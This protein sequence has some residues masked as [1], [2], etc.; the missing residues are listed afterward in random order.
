MVRAYREVHEKSA[1]KGINL[2]QAAFQLGVERLARA[3]ELRGFV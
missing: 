3:V 1:S 2:R